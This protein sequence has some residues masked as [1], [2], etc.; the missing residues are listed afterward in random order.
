MSIKDIKKWASRP[1]STTEV[2][3]IV[4]NKAN[5][6]NYRKLQKY[7]NIDDALGKW[8]A[9]ILLYESRLNFGHWT[10]VFRADDGTL[11][12]FDAYGC[13]PDDEIKHVPEY[14]RKLHYNKI[15]H[16]TYLLYMSNE[17]VRYSQYK[18]QKLNP[19]INTCG[20]WVAMRLLC[21]HIDEDQFHDLMTKP[22]YIN[23][24]YL[25]TLA[26]EPLL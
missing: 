17:P 11:E 1:L 5:V 26:T 21:R 9:V 18:L 16:L 7:D 8:G 20:R 24:D 2:M 10:L 22:K 12:H 14:F 25:V 19:K 4:N 3:K 23:P 6:M 13:K 15:P